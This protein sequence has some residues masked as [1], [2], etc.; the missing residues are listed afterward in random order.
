MSQHRKIPYLQV[1]SDSV[2]F[3]ELSEHPRVIHEKAMHSKKT[4]SGQMTSHAQRRVMRAVDILLQKSPTRRIFNPIIQKEHDFRIAFTTLTIPTH[5][6][7]K[8]SVGHS[9][10]LQPFLRTARRKWGVEDYI[11]KAELQE[12]GQ[13]H[14]HVT[15]NRFIEFTKIRDEWNKL[16][17]RERLSDEYAARYGHFNPNSTDVHAVWKIRNLKA[18]LAKYIA[19]SEQNKTALDGRVWDAS[20]S[21]KVAPFTTVLHAHHED[22]IRDGIQMGLVKVWEC[23]HAVLFKMENPTSVLTQS[24][25]ASYKQHMI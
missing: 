16:L 11:W 1:R 2:L 10:L 20:K 23:D 15:W 22:M 8:A 21:L 3:Y 6:T 25:L 24:E 9:K 14:Y 17:R 5:K 13:L 7:V 4:Y 19:K 18:Y 12:R